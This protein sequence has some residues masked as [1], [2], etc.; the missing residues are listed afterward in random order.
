MFKENDVV[1]Y[2]GAEYLVEKVN[3]KTLKTIHM[4]TGKR[5][6]LPHYVKFLRKA[7]ATDLVIKAEA[8]A[9]ALVLGSVVKFVGKTSSTQNALYVVL[10]VGSNSLVK[11]AKLGGDHDRFYKNVNPKSLKAVEPSD[12]LK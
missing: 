5:W 10:G 1:Y 7:T 6:T 12:F 3:P 9:T 8:V 4:S 11:V 2:D